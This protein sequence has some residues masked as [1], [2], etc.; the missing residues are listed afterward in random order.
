MSN[1]YARF[2]QACK[3]IGSQEWVLNMENRQYKS[4]PIDDMRAGVRKACA[5]AGIV[6]VGPIDTEYTREVVDGRTFRY[7]GSCKFRY[8]STENPEEFIEFESAGEAMDNGDKGMAKF[9]TNLIKNHYK[10]AFDIGELG[11]DDIDS[12]SNEE[13][14]EEADRISAKRET[15]KR[16]ATGFAQAKECK[17]AINKWMGLSLDNASHE[18]IASYAGRFGTMDSWR[19]GTFIQC[20]K[21]LR[22]AG[23]PLKEVQL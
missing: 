23:V 1:V 19:P 14:Y 18:V 16:E 6:H 15:A 13:L 4:I 7:Y 20:Y 17:D 5:E 9:I 22:D 10:A 11:K 8:V 3:L 2:S 21:E 12:Y